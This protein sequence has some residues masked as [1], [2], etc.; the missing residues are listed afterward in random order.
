V[1]QPNKLHIPCVCGDELRTYVASEK[2]K[3]SIVGG[4]S[5]INKNYRLTTSETHGIPGINF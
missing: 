3:K 2:Q 5:S 4:D 1:N